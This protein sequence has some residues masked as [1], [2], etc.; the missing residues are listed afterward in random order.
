MRGLKKVYVAASDAAPAPTPASAAIPAAAPAGPPAPP[1]SSTY[2]PQSERF[3]DK[4][5]LALYH[6][7]SYFVKYRSHRRKK[8][9]QGGE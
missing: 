9:S 3:I 2:A 5:K 4:Y 7:Y 1:F 8:L 6:H